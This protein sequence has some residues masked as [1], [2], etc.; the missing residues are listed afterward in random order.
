MA[1]ENLPRPPSTIFLLGSGASKPAGL[2]IIDEMTK[3]F[4]DDPSRN[5]GIDLAAE[6]EF[7]EFLRIPDN[8]SLLK[9]ITCS[10]FP[11][12]DLEYLMSM[13][14]LL[15]DS[16]EKELYELK[17]PKLKKIDKK[18]LVNLKFAIQEFIRNKCEDI[19]SIDYLIPLK[20]MTQTSKLRI[21]TLNYDGTIEIF[22]EKNAIS[23]TDGFNPDWKP[24]I[25]DNFTGIQLYKLHGSL[26]W[27]KTESNKTIRVPLKG[28]WISSI[29]YITDETI[30][31][32]MIYPSL[33]KNKQSG[34][35]SWLSHRFRDALNSA[36]VCVIIGYSFRDIDIKESIIESMLNKNNL[37]LVIVSPN[38]S[39]L[40]NENFRNNGDFPLRVIAID[41]GIEEV[42]K[43][44]RL[45]GYLR[46]LEN[47][48]SIEDRGWIAQLDTSFRLDEN[49]WNFI[50]RNYLSIG[51]HDR[52][53]SIV[54][55]LPAK[56]F[57]QI[58]GNF[59]DCIE[60]VVG[61]K[62]L[63]YALDYLRDG[64][65][66]EAEF[67]KNIFI[68]YSKCTEYRFFALSG[69]PT[70]TVLNSVKEEQLPSWHRRGGIVPNQQIALFKEEIDR[71]IKF[72]QIDAELMKK[73][74]KLS[75]TL[76]LLNGWYTFA[77]E[78]SKES[79]FVEEYKKDLGL[80]KWAIEIISS[81]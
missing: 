4:L 50:V 13:I 15:E 77:Y 39:T 6:G 33:Q 53:K 63:Q 43:N 31:E 20:S 7:L 60:G 34:V 58:G 55:R 46:S 41:D 27:F 28:L 71:L 29:S 68:E 8:M 79:D 67:W 66:T 73:V 61:H 52:V 35:Y 70:I 37:W 44:G 1:Q 69:N 74:S 5:I 64:K 30:S 57:V 78:P 23:Y 21:F 10:R 38:A 76:D 2:P 48:R 26:Y 11:K 25:F 80:Q 59:P 36:D 47:A 12:Y 51:H 18:I 62:A 65:K 81:M 45:T 14:L 40:K 9:D 75:Q 22:C 3:E 19:K 49:F 17:F 24:E 42:L 32:M 56:D 16:H 54:E 72:E